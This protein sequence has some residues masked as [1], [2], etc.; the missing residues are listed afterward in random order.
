MFYSL[1]YRVLV[2]SLIF[3]ALNLTF[4]VFTW[5]VPLDNIAGSRL[6]E[7]PFFMRMGRAGIYFMTMLG[8]QYGILVKKIKS[9]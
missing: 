4:G 6:D 9:W 2:I 8:M 1:N 3:E 7:I 5:K